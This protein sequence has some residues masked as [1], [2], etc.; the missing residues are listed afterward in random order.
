MNE[1]VRDLTDAERQK[2]IGLASACIRKSRWHPG[3]IK[4]MSECIML[5]K[6]GWLTR[7]QFDAILRAHQ[8]IP[9]RKP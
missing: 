4:F 8:R 1:P 5:A 2:A 3:T 9:G 6:K 7:G